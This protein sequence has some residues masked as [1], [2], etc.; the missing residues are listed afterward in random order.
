MGDWV[1]KQTRH[2]FDRAVRLCSIDMLE[3]G[4][5]EVTQHLRLILNMDS[6]EA[7]AK[8]RVYNSWQ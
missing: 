1:E 6:D 4:R 2:L 7:A 8:V 3:D 5:Y